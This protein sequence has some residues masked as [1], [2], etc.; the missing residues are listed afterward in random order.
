MNHYKATDPKTKRTYDMVCWNCGEKNGYRLHP[1]TIRGGIRYKCA[2]CGE[3]TLLRYER[4]MWSD[5]CPE[6]PGYD[7]ARAEEYEESFTNR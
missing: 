7:E 2:D 5:V 3:F 1:T 6:W 4:D